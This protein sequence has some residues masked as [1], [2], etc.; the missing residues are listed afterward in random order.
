MKV[1]LNIDIL[2]RARLVRLKSHNTYD[3]DLK[4]KVGSTTTIPG[5]E[6]KSFIYEAVSDN[7]IVLQR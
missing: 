5:E 2:Y 3:T 4:L 6:V 7:S 1:S